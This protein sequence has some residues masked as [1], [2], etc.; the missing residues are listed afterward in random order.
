[1]KTINLVQFI[2]ANPEEVFSAITNPFT[3]ELWSGY[4]A[5]M[6]AVEGTEFS[7]FDGDIT[8][9]NI[10]VVE[11]EL[12]VQEWYFEDILEKSYATIQLKPHLQGTK[13]TMEHINIPD[14]AHENILIGWRDYYWG[15]IKEFFK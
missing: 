14:E 10:K 12:L 8:G 4:P 3:I 13:V 15:P 6:E 7:L 9:M 5:K 2:N 11:N 1:M